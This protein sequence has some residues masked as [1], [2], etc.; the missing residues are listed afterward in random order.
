M[1]EIEILKAAPLCSDGVESVTITI[2][3]EFPDMADAEVWDIEN[4]HWHNAQALADALIFSLPGGTLD[5]LTCLLMEKKCSLFRV[6]LFG[7]P[8]TTP[9]E[10]LKSKINALAAQMDAV[11]SAMCEALVADDEDWELLEKSGDLAGLARLVRGWAVGIDEVR[12]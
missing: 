9:I 12:K 4:R 1:K 11:A 10:S 7:L 6:P 3:R 5:R 8:A 2:D